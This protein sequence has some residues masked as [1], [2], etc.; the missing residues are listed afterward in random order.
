MKCKRCGAKLGELGPLLCTLLC[1]DCSKLRKCSHPRSVCYGAK[2]YG[3]GGTRRNVGPGYVGESSP[4]YRVI[5]GGEQQGPLFT[6]LSSARKLRD[7]IGGRIYGPIG[8][9]PYQ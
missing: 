2:C 9:I 8:E 7:S 5:L 1:S 4:A 6:S 3:C